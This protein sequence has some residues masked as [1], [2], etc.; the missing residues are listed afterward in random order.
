VKFLTDYQD[1]A[2]A[3]RYSTLVGKVRDA[4]TRVMPGITELTEAVARYYFKLLAVKDEYEVARLYAETDFE[5][6]VAAQF[7]GDYKLTYNLA[8]PIFNKRDPVTGVPKKSVYGPWMM[9]AFRVLAKMRKYR[10]TAL[11]I[12]G[13]TDERRKERALIAEYE[14]IVAEILAKLTPQN[15]T[16]AVELASVPEHIRGYGHVKDAHLT[17]AKTREAAL[18]AAFR[19]PVPAAKPAVVRVVV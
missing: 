16:T 13:K 7:E 14:A 19:A 10:G 3:Q 11:D 12:F 15:H 6:L 17:T 1:A 18:L 5:K 8:P 9:K 2:Y 4:E